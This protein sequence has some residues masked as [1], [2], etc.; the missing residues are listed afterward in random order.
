LADAV[1]SAG[2]TVVWIKTTYS[3]D[4]PVQWSS[5]LDAYLKERGIDTLVITGCLTDVC[6]ESTSR[7]AMMLNYRV[8][9]VTDANAAD[10]DADHNS[11]L[12]AVYTT[13]GDI[14]PTDM[15]VGLLA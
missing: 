9:L 7:D 13:S 4:E 11:A 3:D 10:T 15:V 14:T 8:I 2:A 5:G 6:S 1:R 12:C